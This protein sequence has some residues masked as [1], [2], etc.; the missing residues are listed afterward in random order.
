MKGKI[1]QKKQ[2]STGIKKKVKSKPKAASKG[3]VV[4]GKKGMK[5]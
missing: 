5:E 4:R 3:K 2:K 1:A